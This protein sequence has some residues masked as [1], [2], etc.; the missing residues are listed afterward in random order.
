ME[1]IGV[2]VNGGTMMYGSWQFSISWSWIYCQKNRLDKASSPFM[3]C[4]ECTCCSLPSQ[5]CRGPPQVQLSDFRLP[6]LQANINPHS[7][8]TILSHVLFQQ[9]LKA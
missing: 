4:T 7:L 8:H 3:L 5:S 2:G 9:W 1:P 6:E